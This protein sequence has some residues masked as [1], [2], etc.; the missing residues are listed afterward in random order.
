MVYISS[1]GELV[2]KEPITWK[3]PLKMFWKIIT[4][5]I[6]FFLSMFHMEHLWR[7][8]RVNRYFMGSSGSFYNDDDDRR[9]PGGGGGGG[10]GNGPSGGGGWGSGVNRRIHTL[11]R[12]SGMGVPTCPGGS[13]GR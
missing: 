11:P 7:N 8:S 13:C 4:F 3:T 10:G 5:I 9:G 6:E 1:S 12:N 2:E